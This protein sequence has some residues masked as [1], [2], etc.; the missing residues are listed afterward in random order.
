MWLARSADPNLLVDETLTV[1][2]AAIFGYFEKL[3]QLGDP[4]KVVQE[5][6]RLQTL[7]E[8]LPMAGY[9]MTMVD[10]FVEST[11]DLLEKVRQSVER[12]ETTDTLLLEAF[13]EHGDSDSIVFSFKVCFLMALQM[14]LMQSLTIFNCD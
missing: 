1:H 9:D 10:M 11:M 7:T 4:Q 8:S 2:S 13:N 3:L 12:K 5:M 6:T 14:K